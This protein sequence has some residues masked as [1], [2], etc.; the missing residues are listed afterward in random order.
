DNGDDL[1]DDVARPLHGDGIALTDVDAPADRLTEAVEAPDVV[2]VVERRVFDDDPAHGHRR[3]P[4]DRRERAGAADLDVDLPQRRRRLLGRELVRDR[5][6][7]F[8]G[9]GAPAALQFEVV[10]LVDDAVDVVAEA[11]ALR[12]DQPVVR[13]QLLDRAD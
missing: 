11:R 12:L 8:A 6:A 10:E 1:R 7:R 4:G 5:P 2:L 9:Y 3:E 13:E